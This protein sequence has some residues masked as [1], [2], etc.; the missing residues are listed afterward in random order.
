VLNA[1]TIEQVLAFEE[2]ARR[3]VAFEIIEVAT[4]F[5]M[6]SS[7]DGS[8]WNRYVEH[9]KSRTERKKRKQA[10]QVMTREQAALLKRMLTRKAN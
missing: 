2:A 9:M 1:Y 8:A 5:R 6:A 10:P 4:A 7:R 3:N